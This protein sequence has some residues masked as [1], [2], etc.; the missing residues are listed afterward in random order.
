MS[1]DEQYTKEEQEFL[2]HVERLE[3]RPL[4]PQQKHHSVK[5][6]GI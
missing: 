4:T 3:G 2:K 5:Q 1:A 6:R